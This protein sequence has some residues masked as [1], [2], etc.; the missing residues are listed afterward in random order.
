M[1]W[2][3]TNSRIELTKDCE[4]LELANKQ[5]KSENFFPILDWCLLI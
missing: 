4:H 2:I 5:K 1:L 3:A